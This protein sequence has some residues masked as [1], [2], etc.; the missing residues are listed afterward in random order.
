MGINKSSLL[1]R[2]EE[3]AQIQEATGCKCTII[4][5]VKSKILFTTFR[6]VLHPQ[7]WRKLYFL[8]SMNV[9]YIK[10]NFDL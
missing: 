4:V 5:F 9:S 3:I 1:L 2:E 8:I 6:N 7:K 10:L